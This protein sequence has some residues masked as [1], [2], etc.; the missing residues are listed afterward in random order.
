MKVDVLGNPTGKKILLLP[1]KGYTWQVYFQ[2]L[3]PCLERDYKI[4]CI[5]YTGFGDFNYPFDSVTNEMERIEDAI[6]EKC[7]GHVNLAY[8]AG[9][10]S[11]F[12]GMIVNRNFVKI[13]HLVIGSYAFPQ[14]GKRTAEF[15]ADY[16][17]TL[18]ERQQKKNNS[19]FIK[20][21]Q[22]KGQEWAEESEKFTEEACQALRRV[23]P[24]S[25]YNMIYTEVTTPLARKIGTPGC[26]SHIM[27]SR[28]MGKKHLVKAKWHFSE[29]DV[30]EFS[31]GPE[32]WM[33]YGDVVKKEFEKYL[34]VD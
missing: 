12:L 28:K 24:A 9:I 31:M 26:T 10:G 30:N 6:K 1:G 4:I 21:M 17:K 7:G 22:R 13:D 3:I 2:R 15:Y 18:F 5:N 16:V 32:G 11:K 8:G 27:F 34:G 25:I 33:I 20:H 23:D 14:M 29:L 19:A